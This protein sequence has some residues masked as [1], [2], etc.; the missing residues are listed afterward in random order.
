VTRVAFGGRAIRWAVTGVK[1][2]EASKGTMR[3]PTPLPD[4]EGCVRG[5]AIGGSRIGLRNECGQTMNGPIRPFRR[6]Q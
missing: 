3:K 6:G 4:G 1:H 5:E 2:E